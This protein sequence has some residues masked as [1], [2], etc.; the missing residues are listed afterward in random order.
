[1]SR[2]VPIQGSPVLR[3]ALAA[4]LA[5]LLT[6]CGGGS[7]SDDSSSSVSQS[8]ASSSSST[9]LSSGHAV[10]STSEAVYA[11]TAQVVSATRTAQATRRTASSASTQDSSDVIS[12]TVKCSAGGSAD[13]D[14][15]GGTT[16]SLLNG[17]LDAGEHYAISFSS[18]VTPGGGITLEGD[19]ALDVEAVSTD[20]ESITVA[21]TF[22][23][24]QATADSDTTTL[25]GQVTLTHSE[26]T[27]DATTTVTSQI[28]A[29]KIELATEWNSRR[30]NLTLTDVDVTATTAWKGGVPA[31]STLKGQYSLT[32]TTDDD[33][34]DDSV[35]ISSG[36]SF[37]T[38]GHPTSGSWSTVG[39]KGTLTTTAADSK[40]TIEIDSDN[41]GTVD[42]T[43]T[44]T[45][46]D[47]LSYA[48]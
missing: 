43:W 38:D 29:D 22:S 45:I 20:P 5:A 4:S 25:N 15:S 17:Q 37:D 30:A 47:W 40:L 33:D 11:S 13:I 36:V 6:A 31:S 34:F 1:M 28:S 2:S 41:D 24:L 44:V 35:S 19:V 26:S 14:I 21:V 18:C 42:H 7:S 27:S 46:P 3:F 32:G 48:G 8:E 9:S 10:S 23:A 16:D 12:F 39:S